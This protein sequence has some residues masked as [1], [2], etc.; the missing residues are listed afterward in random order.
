MSL[1][2]SASQLDKSELAFKSVFYELCKFCMTILLAPKPSFWPEKIS[3]SGRPGFVRR[4]PSFR[5][6]LQAAN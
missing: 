3:F 2:K 5:R 1:F 6:T 4:G